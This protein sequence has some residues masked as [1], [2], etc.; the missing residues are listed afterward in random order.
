MQLSM[1]GFNDGKTLLKLELI[2]TAVYS[3]SLK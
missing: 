1:L 3:S 2:Y